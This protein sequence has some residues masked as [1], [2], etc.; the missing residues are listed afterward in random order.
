MSVAHQEHRRLLDTLRRRLIS[1]LKS[2]KSALQKE[3]EKLDIADTNALLYHPN[4][5][6]LNNGASPG[7]PQSN[8]KTRHTRHRLEVDDLDTTSSNY[9]KKRKALADAD[10]GSPAP[11]GREVE[12]ANAFKEASEKLEYH[13]VAAP[14]YSLDRLFMQKELDSNLQ[15]ATCEVVE[16]L[17]RRKLNKDSTTNINPIIGINVD[18]SDTE[19]NTEA[20]AGLDGAAEDMFLGAPEM[21]RTATSASQHLTRSTRGL[22]PLKRTSGP[23]GLG[24]LAGRAS[25]AAFIGNCSLKE[26][27]R[28]DD[29]NR[30]PPLSDLEADD[31]IAVMKA[32]TEDQEA[33]KPNPLLVESAV[34]IQDRE[35]YVGTGSVEGGEDENDVEA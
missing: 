20:G 7:G 2:R 14:I 16:D 25:G 1:N 21:E 9:K 22:I 6:S 32:A 15:L 24:N 34:E 28:E 13:Q 31:D 30:A 17:K 27:K 29:Y 19:A 3:K 8:R 4:Q 26:K 23:E 35:D 18:S 10:S 5:F 11:P 12:P 33:G